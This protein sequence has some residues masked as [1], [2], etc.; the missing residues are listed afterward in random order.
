[1][2]TCMDQDTSM[3][4]Q[5]EVNRTKPVKFRIRPGTQDAQVFEEVLV[6]NQYELPSVFTSDFV[7]I[8]IGAHI[9]AFAVACFARQA[10]T[11]VCFEPYAHNYTLLE[12]NIQPWREQAAAFNAAVWRSDKK[13]DV[14]LG[15]GNAQATACGTV[16]PHH[17]DPTLQP[18]QAIGLN[19]IINLATDGGRRRVNLLKIDAEGSEYPILYT[20]DALSLVDSIIVETHDYSELGVKEGALVDG[21]AVNQC[22]AVGMVAFLESK[23]FGCRVRRESFTNQIN[24]L[25]WATRKEAV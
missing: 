22:S 1:M 2:T 14:V 16:F 3:N 15:G 11:V 24:N 25:M 21:F 18:V 8:D 4:G 5:M 7:V 12:Q 19:H 10:K 9:G 6:N 20:C 23:G 13:E 17:L